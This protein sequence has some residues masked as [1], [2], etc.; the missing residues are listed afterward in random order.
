MGSLTIKGSTSGD[1]T[2]AAPAVAG[3]STLNLPAAN[4]TLVTLAATQTLTNKTIGASQLTGTVNALRLPAGTIL[5]VLQGSL[6]TSFTGTGVSGATNYW[7]TV[8]GLSVTI[9]PT[10]ATSKILV[11]VDMYVGLS[12]T[13]NGYQQQYRILRNSSAPSALLGSAE[14]G[15]QGVTGQIN[16]YGGQT[17]TDIQYRMGFLGGR[18]LDSPATTSALT[19]EVQLRGY[20]GT[21]TV[22]VNRSQA[23]Q[24]GGSDYDGVPL[25]TITVMEIAQ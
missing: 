11:N 7:V 3:T 13:S 21:P 6:N 25:S 9:T 24:A 20:S 17:T 8:T 15:R 23:F 5:Q 4:D 22:Y 19:Y 2:L 14:G 18:H 10:S 1:V 12:T 16:M